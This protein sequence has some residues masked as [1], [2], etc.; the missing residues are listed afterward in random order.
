V[1]LE[2]IVT[3]L[4]EKGANVTIGDNP[5]GKVEKGTAEKIWKVTGIDQISQKTGC[6]KSI[7]DRSG[8]KKETFNLNGQSFSYYISADYINADL[9]INV[10]KFKSHALTGFTGA[11]KNIFGIVPG[12][13]KVQ[14]HGFAP[15]PWDFA[16]VIVDIYG[17]RPPE[18]TIM[19]AIRGI[20]GDGPGIK[21]KV[22][23]IGLFMMGNDGV[24]VDAISTRIM[25]L[26][27]DHN[28]IVTEALEKK[29][30][31]KEPGNIYLE[32]FEQLSDCY[33]QDFIPPATMRFRNPKVLKK[34]SEIAKFRIGI[35]PDKCIACLKCVENCPVQCI[36]H[37][38][39]NELEI[40]KTR[41]IQCLCCLEICPSA[42]ID[43][44]KSKFYQDLKKIKQ[45]TKN[46]KENK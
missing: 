24:L 18:I 39:A 5:I 1:L 27:L 35:N 11:V 16:K 4:V 30:G 45:R 37:N 12:R 3:L 40:D 10:P 41:C 33:L 22:K 29:L 43:V 2:Q 26:T 32:G 7:L 8:L 31:N 44:L 9:V 34:L 46:N 23:K 28:F 6:R 14:L 15:A 21:G 19:D 13:A 36:G 17:K 42:A 38:Q 20:E 25:G